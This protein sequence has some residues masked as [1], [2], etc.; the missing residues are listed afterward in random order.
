MISVIWMMPFLKLKFTPTSFNTSVGEIE[1]GSFS[2]GSGGNLGEASFEDITGLNP[3]LITPGVT[4][5]PAGQTPTPVNIQVGANSDYFVSATIKNG[6][7]DLTI[8]N[9]LGFDIDV[10][11][12]DLRS[13]STVI[14]STT[15]Q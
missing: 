9:N 11:D 12:I 7:V 13:G 5:I 14:T 15:Y 10:V 1:I 2:S 3:A 6:S 8:T 4:T